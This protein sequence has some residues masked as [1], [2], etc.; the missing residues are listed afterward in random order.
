MTWDAMRSIMEDLQVPPILQS[1]IE[2]H[3]DSGDYETVRAILNQF[4]SERLNSGCRPINVRAL[5]LAVFAPPEEWGLEASARIIHRL[6]LRGG[7]ELHQCL[8]RCVEDEADARDWA[9]AK[10]AQRRQ[11]ERPD[12]F[13][14]PPPERYGSPAR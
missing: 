5:R 1:T 13:P 8:A 12:E 4:A 2:M 6:S 11:G 9:R 7:P 14:D 10:E 3:F